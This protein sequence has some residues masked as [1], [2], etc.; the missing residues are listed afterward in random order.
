MFLFIIIKL[1]NNSISIL[2]YLQ[3]FGGAVIFTKEDFENVEGEILVFVKTFDDMFSTTV[4]TST[5]YTFNELIYGAKFDLMYSENEDKTKTI[6]HLDK[7]NS[8]QLVH[9]E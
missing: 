9:L 8:Y 7:L 3:Y 5:S 1:T 6:L 4:A 2:P